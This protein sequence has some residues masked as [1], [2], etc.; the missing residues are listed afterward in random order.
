MADVSGAIAGPVGAAPPDGVSAAAR[1]IV[2]SAGAGPV[3]VSAAVRATVGL[4][5]GA[6]AGVLSAIGPSPASSGSSWPL[7]GVRESFIAVS[8]GRPSSSEDTGPLPE[9][10]TMRAPRERSRP[11]RARKRAS[12]C[13]L[14]GSGSFSAAAIDTSCWL[15]DCGSPNIH[16]AAKSVMSGGAQDGRSKPPPP[17]GASAA[18]GA[19]A[20]PGGVGGAG[21][22][23]GAGVRASRVDASSSFG[24]CD[25]TTACAR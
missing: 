17:A 25:S 6:G 1:A 20:A 18:V 2:G 16:C 3:G 5:A 8:G 23:G 19:A 11:P 7:T 15:A 12:F 13:C 21:A 9:P 14:D 4:V 24:R 10:S 22:A